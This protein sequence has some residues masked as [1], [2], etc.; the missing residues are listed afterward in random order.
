[1]IERLQAL[2]I[3][4]TWREAEASTHIFAKQAFSEL[5]NAMHKVNE[6]Y[7]VLLGNALQYIK[8]V[9]EDND[10]AARAWPRRR[11]EIN[12]NLRIQMQ[13]NS[14][15]EVLIEISVTRVR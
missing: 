6:R 9:T 2:E 10:S 4:E 11:F 5:H 8:I 3:G 15:M 12:S 7:R 14:R 1:M 13:T